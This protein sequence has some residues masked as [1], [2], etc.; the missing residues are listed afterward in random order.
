M[1]PQQN[2]TQELVRNS[3]PQTL[4]GFLNQT[5]YVSNVLG[6]FLCW[7]HAKEWSY[8]STNL[9]SKLDKKVDVERKNIAISLECAVGGHGIFLSF[10]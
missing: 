5:L 4:L 3:D 6:A 2:T 1:K 7:V 8:I 9:S 10:S